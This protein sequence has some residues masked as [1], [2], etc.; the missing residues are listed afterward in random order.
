MKKLISIIL[1]SLMAT[2][3]SYAQ[4]QE[5]ITLMCN[6]ED[7]DVPATPIRRAP[8][9]YV[10]EYIEG[11]TISFNKIRAYSFLAIYDNSGTLICSTE[12]TPDY[13]TYSLPTDLKGEYKVVLSIGSIE[14]VGYMNIN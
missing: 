12:L 7:K 3:N 9:P 10:Y 11:N 8:R 2:F 13:T 1:L 14:Y 6:H 5:K 4:N